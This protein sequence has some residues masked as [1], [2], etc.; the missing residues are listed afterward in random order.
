MNVSGTKSSGSVPISIGVT[1]RSFGPAS[2]A[3]QLESTSDVKGGRHSRG[4][5]EEG[6]FAG[7]LDAVNEGAPSPGV[8][9][10]SQKDA[11]KWSPAEASIV[12]LLRGQRLRILAACLATMLAGIAVTAIFAESMK[13]HAQEQ[14]AAHLRESAGTQL[15][16]WEALTALHL[17]S[18]ERF[19]DAFVAR[20]N[21]THPLEERVFGEIAERMAF[22]A[23][24]EVISTMAVMVYVSHEER[25]EW[26]RAVGP[27]MAPPQEGNPLNNFRVI[28][29][30]EQDYFLV[31]RLAYNLPSQMMGKDY[32]RRLPERFAAIERSI[33]EQRPVATGPTEL[34]TGSRAV[35]F[36][37]PIRSDDLAV[38]PISGV[39]GM[40]VV[41]ELFASP[42]KDTSDFPFLSHDATFF[43]LVD[44]TD[45]TS[46]VVIAATDAPDDSPVIELAAADEDVAT[47]T[48][49]CEIFTT[50]ATVERLTDPAPESVVWTIGLLVSCSLTAVVFACIDACMQ[51]RQ[52]NLVRFSAF[53]KAETHDRV[54][55]TL[56]HELRNPLTGVWAGVEHFLDSYAPLLS[57][58]M[59]NDLDVVVSCARTMHQV[60]DELLD[61]QRLQHGE[62]T[63]RPRMTRLDAFARDVGNMMRAYLPPGVALGFSVARSTP[64]SASFDRVRIRQI[65]ANAIA[66]AC[67]HAAPQSVIEVT[68]SWVDGFFIVRVVDVGEPLPSKLSEQQLLGKVED[69]DRNLP[70]A[71]V[72]K[73]SEPLESAACS[74]TRWTSMRGRRGVLMTDLVSHKPQAMRSASL[75]S[76]H[77]AAADSSPGLAASLGLPL[78]F[79]VAKAMGGSIG[80]H[81]ITLKRSDRLSARRGVSFWLAVPAPRSSDGAVRGQESDGSMLCDS[82]DREGSRDDRLS[83]DSS[84]YGHLP[85]AVHS[86]DDQQTLVDV[87]RYAAGRE[88]RG[89]TRPPASVALVQDD[90]KIGVEA[91]PDQDN[92]VVVDDEAVIRRIAGRLITKLGGRVLGSFEDGADLPKQLDALE[93][94]PTCILLDIV[95]LRSNGIAVIRKLRSL[96][97]WQQLPVYAMTSNVENESV[98]LYKS[99]GFT[100]VVGKPFTLMLLR[101]ALEHAH[102]P[103]KARK[104]L[105]ALSP[106][107]VR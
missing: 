22:S 106:E 74:Y 37:V 88:R 24:A 75:S 97:K 10:G 76:A 45:V 40:S 91:D 83:A 3:S 36:Q 34:A 5:R 61:T 70:P 2:P 23:G 101:E 25:V 6:S 81:D 62:V 80:V 86:D 8:H 95:M 103:P 77:R 56:S 44:V 69:E 13:A 89:V 59:R 29:N 19:A 16:K 50:T 65:V 26:E 71:V 107:G 87:T 98:D 4:W 12:R 18:L 60:L 32:S 105:A 84:N 27:I 92:I 49:R 54:L 7:D 93:V 31:I 99:S 41:D 82:E 11:V 104:F 100:G 9:L 79:K 43:S 96:P 42:L 52:Q 73:L 30:G 90:A 63:I 14:V 35:P 66:N 15:A 46:P 39:L 72:R 78:S 21:R 64:K 28:G 17:L 48:W 38:R 67:H 94:P 57:S 102:L 1:P 55:T 58:E 85:G 51:R 68:Y 53:I 33:A 20:T 47:R